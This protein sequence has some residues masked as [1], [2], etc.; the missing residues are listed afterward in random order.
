MN[1][2]P[3]AE[4]DEPLCMCCY[5]RGVRR[6]ATRGTAA[7]VLLFCTECWVTSADGLRCLAKAITDTRPPDAPVN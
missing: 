7:D 5:E 3:T 2:T 6:R 1:D 4:S